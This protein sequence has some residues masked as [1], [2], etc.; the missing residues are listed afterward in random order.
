MTVSA[1]FIVMISLS[2]SNF[3]ALH[4]DLR[5]VAVAIFSLD[6]ADLDSFMRLSPSEGRNSMLRGY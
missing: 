3:T 6:F 5:S 1:L 2:A 4:I